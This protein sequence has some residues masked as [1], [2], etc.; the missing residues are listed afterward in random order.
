ML[1]SLSGTSGHGS[2]TEPR[3][4]PNQ[5]YSSSAQYLHPHLHFHNPTQALLSQ[6]L[7]PE[8]SPRP[9]RTG[10]H[11]S[12]L[13]GKVW[14]RGNPV[15]TNSSFLRLARNRTSRGGRGGEGEGGLLLMLFFFS[16]LL[17]SK[18]KRETYI[19]LFKYSC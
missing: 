15:A 1:L 3:P 19:G 2:K 18:Q 11:R 16:F 14:G 13:E 8:A 12:H 10:R 5:S 9:A 17:T 6:L 7:P 4:I